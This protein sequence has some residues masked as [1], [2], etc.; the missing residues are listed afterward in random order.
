MA[1]TIE[2]FYERF[3]QFDNGSDEQVEAILAEAGTWVD[4]TW[5]QTD[6][7]NAVMYLSAHMLSVEQANPDGGAAGAVQSES[8]GPISVSYAVNQAS[9]SDLSA[10]KSTLYGQRYLALLN[11][12]KRGPILA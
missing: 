11:R 12:N 4:A 3:P 7:D 10:L 1:V 5:N 9:G 8:F 6:A 2:Q